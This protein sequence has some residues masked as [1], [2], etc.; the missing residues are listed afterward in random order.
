VN[1]VKGTDLSHG[2]AELAELIQWR[3]GVWHDLGYENPPMP[4]CKAI[5]PLGERSASAIKGAHA[6][7]EAIDELTRQLSGL[8]QQ[9][10]GELR[11]DEDVRLSERLPHRGES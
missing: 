8:R 9:L 6:A 11:A 10:V 7:V 2:I 1:G 3:V 5:P 4:D